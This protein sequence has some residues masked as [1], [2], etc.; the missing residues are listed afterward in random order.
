MAGGERKLLLLLLLS[1]ATPG[2]ET[3]G[4]PL[5]TLLLLVRFPLASPRH[6]VL[7]PRPAIS[8]G[9]SS[10]FCCLLLT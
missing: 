3:R 1:S 4:L 7:Q 10:T 9:E 2:R 6:I 5:R 8:A